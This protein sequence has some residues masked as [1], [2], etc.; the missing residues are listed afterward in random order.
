[1]K[2]L[3]EFFISLS[4]VGYINF[5]SGTW[6]SL[7][8]IIIIFLLFKLLSFSILISLF[9]IIFVISNFLINYFSSFTNT[10]DS[11]HIVID[12]F[13]GVFTVFFFYDLI[14][15]KNDLI[16]VMLIFFTFR[17]F[18]MFKIFPANYIDKNFKNGFGVIIDDIIA[19]MYTILILVILN[20]FI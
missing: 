1:M 18:D 3:T 11:K 6:G 5:A 4:Y 2:K 12:E 7:V 13:L 17:F 10:Q 19:G 8:S 15:I 14:F 16:T 20:A 9:I